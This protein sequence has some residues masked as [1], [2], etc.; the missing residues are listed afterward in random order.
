MSPLRNPEAFCGGE[1]PEQDRPFTW[2][3][4]TPRISMVYDIMGDGRW[5]AKFSYSRY[6]ESLG[7]RFVGATNVNDVA[8]EDWNWYDPNGDGLFQ[9]GEQ[10]TFRSQ[11]IPGEGTAIDPDLHAPMTNEFTFG[12]DH[13]IVDNVLLSVTGIIRGRD[14]DTGTVE[15]GRPF[16]PMIDNA[17]CQAECTPTYSDGSPR[18]LYDPWVQVTA[19]DPGNDGIIGNADDGGPVPVWVLDPATYGT[20]VRLTTNVDEWG[21][22]DYIDYKGVSFV[23]SKRW[24]DNWQVLASY[25]YGSSYSR[26]SSTSPN[27]LYNGRRSANGRPHNFKFTGNY[28]I[29]EPIGVNLGMFIRAQSGS[30]LS[31]GYTYSGSYLES[32]GPYPDQ[33]NTGITLTPSGE[34][35]SALNRP[36]YE[37][38]TT[39]V[40]V[41]AE[42]QVTIGKYGVVHF[43]LDVFNLFNANTITRYR[44]G[45]G[46]RYLQIRDI[47][48]PRV[49]RLGGAWDF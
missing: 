2:N 14:G 6:M 44:T 41:R 16:G 11:Y 40:D 27:G 15:I 49:I 45:V 12:I 13:E 30:P 22:E 7:S 35:D 34:G 26:G 24:S 9:F 1:F 31:A 46:P 4:L 42:K 33:S 23:V 47:L 48:P 37:D 18:P 39:I 5:A 19:V 43:Y 29:A 28:L 21:F 38:F 10:E 20:S 36:A 3:N 32:I 25:D 8:S 17:R